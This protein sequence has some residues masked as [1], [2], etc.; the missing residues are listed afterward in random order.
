VITVVCGM[1]SVICCSIRPAVTTTASEGL[2]GVL[3]AVCPWTGDQTANA[4]QYKK[5]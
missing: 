4:L 5:Q 2:S 1:A 3:P